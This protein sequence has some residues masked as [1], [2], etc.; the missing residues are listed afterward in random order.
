MCIREST[1]RS[2]GSTCARTD[3]WAR[4][5][6]SSGWKRRCCDERIDDR[7]SPD[8][9]AAEGRGVRTCILRRMSV[10]DLE[11]RGRAR[12]PPPAGRVRLLQGS[13]DR[14][15]G[16]LRPVSYT[17]LTLPTILRV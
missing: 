12:G 17:H 2:T 4:T 16:R 3:L 5:L 8:T 11:L 1:A 6:N 13:D 15:V 7:S 9:Q 10:A 14:Y